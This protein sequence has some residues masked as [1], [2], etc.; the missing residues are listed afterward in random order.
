[1]P[2]YMW[3]KMTDEAMSI[4]ITQTEFIFKQQKEK[5]QTGIDTWLTHTTPEKSW[6]ERLKNNT[7]DIG[8]LGV[9][10]NNPVDKQYRE[11]LQEAGNNLWVAQV[12]AILIRS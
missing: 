2:L 6:R 10:T 9:S 7:V 11:A 8:S 12:G 3:K 4:W 5:H 1:M